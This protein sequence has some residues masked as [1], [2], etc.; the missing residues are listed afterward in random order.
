M[1]NGGDGFRR[2]RT[3]EVAGSSPA[4][5]THESPA[6]RKIWFRPTIAGS[7]LIYFRATKLCAKTGDAV[8]RLL[9]MEDLS[10]GYTLWGEP[11]LARPCTTVRKYE[12]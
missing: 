12:P 4:S 8:D 10:F 5:S 11:L 9:A 6:N 7:G 3:Q 1:A 2:N